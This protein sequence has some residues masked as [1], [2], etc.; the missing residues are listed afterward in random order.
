VL[1][2]ALLLVTLPGQAA[3]DNPLDQL[4]DRSAEHRWKTLRERLADRRADRQERKSTDDD[5]DGEPQPKSSESKGGET[6]G[7]TVS[8]PLPA[9]AADQSWQQAS[10]DSPR[11]SAPPER[12]IPSPALPV[13][14]VAGPSMRAPA[15][16]PA[17]VQAQPQDLA[18][19][20]V[21]QEL[22]QLET[23]EP[24]ESTKSVENNNVAPFSAGPEADPHPGTMNAA[25]AL[26]TS[27]A[28]QT[29]SFTISHPT[30]ASS[31]RSPIPGLLP[32]LP[33]PPAPSHMGLRT[34]QNDPLSEDNGG[35]NLGE[36][37]LAPPEPLLNFD[38]ERQSIDDYLYSE[39]DYIKKLDQIAPFSD[40]EPDPD[41][42]AS[43]PYRNLCPHP[44]GDSE[45][46]LCP[47]IAELPG[48]EIHTHREFAHLD[49]NWAAP[50]ICYNPLYFED[51]ST[52]RY[53]HFHRPLVQPFVSVGKFSVQFLGLPYQ[54][55]MHQPAQATYPLGYFR[56]GDVGAPKLYYQVPLNFKAAVATV[57]VYTGWFF[58]IP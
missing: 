1:F 52:E 19:G 7:K 28:G 37:P 27:K 22:F 33:V 53:G 45:Q 26:L 58:V 29:P 51:V 4:R 35:L 10:P 46:F 48:A 17:P 11:L 25:S 42:R 2:A 15:P 55:A 24:G 5:L 14:A 56:P 18:L 20:S 8:Y 3:D 13:P 34:A 50:N 32:R 47:N 40:Y 9:G 16:V 54:M 57:G 23:I 6:E 41:I 12:A 30:P 36:Q 49:F 39:S 43:D 38:P 44:E 31:P 21:Y